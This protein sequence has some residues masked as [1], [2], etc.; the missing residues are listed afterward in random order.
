MCGQCV[1]VLN[2]LP[3]QKRDKSGTCCCPIIVVMGTSG[4]WVGH[5]PWAMVHL[6]YFQ[7]ILSRNLEKV[8]ILSNKCLGNDQTER[9]AKCKF[10]IE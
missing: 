2:K 1:G 10:W 8:K 7:T 9:T 3:G 6:A 4:C 5:G